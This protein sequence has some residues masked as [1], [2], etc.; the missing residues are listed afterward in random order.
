MSAFH[1]WF[2][3]SLG[4]AVLS[5]AVVA[6]SSAPVVAQEDDDLFS[7]VPAESGTDA[8]AP[9]DAGATDGAAAQPQP[10]QPLTQEEVTALFNEGQ[11]ALEA[12][13]FE[14]ALAAYDRL[15]LEYKNNLAAQNFM[16]AFYTGRGRAFAGME[17][18]EAALADFKEALLVDPNNVAALVARGNLY[19]E[20]GANELALGDF[21]LAAEQNRRDPQVLFGLGKAYALLGGAQ[22][23]VKPLTYVIQ[24]DENNAEAYRLRAQAYAGLGKYPDA[25]ADLE[26]AVSLEP[27]NHEN[28]FTRAAILLREEKFPEA[29]EQINASLENY[30]PKDEAA[31]EPFSQGY[32]TKAAVLEEIGKTAPDEAL[33]TEAYTLA[34]KEC[35]TLLE[36]IGEQPQYA[37]VRAATEFRRGVLLRLMGQFGEAVNA[38]TEAI[39]INPDMTDAYF[40]RGICFYNI[41]EDEM[42]ISD[43]QH[44][45]I[46]GYTDPR[47][48]L[49]EGFAYAKLGEYHQ[50]IRA[51]GQAL[52][53]SDRYVPA[54]VNRGLAYMALDQEDKAIA[55]FNEAIR[56]EPNEWTHYFKRGV[57][58]ERKGDYQEAAVSFSNAIRFDEHHE[59][60]PA[61]RRAANVYTRLGR[62]DL[63]N[64]YRT[65]AGEI[66]SQQPA[67]QQ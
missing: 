40:R 30:K 14:K 15:I 24:G 45:A 18:L 27:E 12:K 26:K 51:Y 4:F 36:L 55:D 48:R 43:F 7:D 38:F 50:A 17:D 10:R 16:P 34:L 25:Y 41:D 29:V 23:A 8:A 54:Y 28:Y 62:T 33:R 21:Q 6:F 2:C 59:Y 49:W 9:A 63:A 56:L 53:L 11:A 19:L 37:G 66:E 20:A 22:Q 31:P 67:Q 46:I 60:A 3:R 47:P 5:L 32:L 57:A 65:K 39:N 58:Q 61:Y 1:S 13:E 35:D 44:A 64:E 42:A 52:A